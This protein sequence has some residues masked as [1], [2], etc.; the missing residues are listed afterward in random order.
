M[1]KYGFKIK[2]YD[3]ADVY[4]YNLGLKDKYTTKDAMLV[5]SLFLDFLL[6]IGMETH[7]DESTRDVICIEFPKSHSVRS[8]DEE[9]THLD[10]IEKKLIKNKEG[11]SE[12]QVERKLEGVKYFREKANENKD[13]FED[14]K[15]NGDDIRNIYYRDGVDITY[16]VWGKRYRKPVIVG[17]ETIHYKRLYRTPGKA[18]KGSCMFIRES[19]FEKAHDFLTMGLELPEENAPIVE[20]EAYSSLI[21]S[22]IVGRIHLDPSE[23]LVI[24]D[25]DSFFKRNVISIETDENKNCFAREI[26]GYELKN[27]MYDGQALIDSSIFPD[28]GDGY[29]LLR[30][31]FCKMAAFNTHIQKFMH[32]YYGDKY[33]SST[34]T[35]IYGIDHKVSDIKLITTEN[36]MKWMKFDVGY[37]YWSEKVRA[38]GSNFGI[39]KTAHQSKLGD[40]Q[41]M[42]YQMVNALDIG[43]MDAVLQTSMDYVKQLQT[44]DEV[45]LDYLEK[46][47]NFSNDFEVLIAL[48]KQNPLFVKSDYFR[49]R[50]RL[51]INAYMINLKSGRAIQNGDNL[52]IVGSP[53]AML[54]SSVGEDPFTDPTFSSEFGAIQCWT[55]RFKDKEYLAEFR[56]PFNSRNNLGILRNHYHEY[57]DRYFNFGKL[58]IAVNMIGTDFQDRNNGSDQDS[59]SIY[60]TNESHIVNHAKWCYEKYPTI[61]NNIPKE[62]N[63]YS[64]TPQELAKLDNSLAAAQIAI[65]SSSNLA[66]ICLTYTYNFDDD[67]YSAYVCILSVL[68]Q[69][70]IDNSKRKYD[71]DLNKSIRDIKKDM[72]INNNGYPAFWR[73]IRRD[74]NNQEKAIERKINKSTDENEKNRLRK[75]LKT[76]FDLMCPM[77][78]VYNIKLKRD[79]EYG[80]IP[81]SEF[82][83]ET[84]FE[85]RANVKIARKI[86]KLIERYSI[87]LAKFQFE[88]YDENDDALMLEE[89]F[90]NLLINVRKTKFSSNYIPLM[91]WLISRAFQIDSNGSKNMK[92]I[93]KTNS[94]LKKNRP[95]L[96]KVLYDLNS[97]MFLKCFSNK[98]KLGVLQN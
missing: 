33:F 47:S 79:F 91:S 65:G 15:L 41:R 36:A 55:E 70:A 75:S 60:V 62:K 90:N 42:S 48:V 72:E 3:A 88:E 59:D 2:N 67:K 78:K 73:V 52:V 93:V 9:L 31:H 74:F 26:D 34:I 7:N 81:L 69:C 49:D 51:I 6:E 68:A 37:E 40:V 86:E 14:R 21:T 57:F 98:P 16:P 45:F 61:V 84:D 35:D 46:N 96:L 19:L 95:L 11:L 10:K 38:N 97:E 58:I 43:N 76:N 64:N 23:I 39:V 63:H 27:T 20:M 30:H 77:N 5:N 87:F 12:E 89:E 28:W 22:S 66:Q 94:I 54:L 32:E 1:G 56:N 29:I 44:N 4:S 80:M 50:R 85:H 92:S 82:F 18:K 83:I 53:Y 13:K 17:E 8:F 24:P 25:V 71:I